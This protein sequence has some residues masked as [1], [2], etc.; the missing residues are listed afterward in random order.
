[1][2]VSRN[3]DHGGQTVHQRCCVPLPLCILFST[4]ALQTKIKNMRVHGISARH[5]RLV[6]MLEL[7]ATHYVRRQVSMYELQS[8]LT[9]ESY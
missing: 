5:R 8:T 4:W 1:M 7:S 9:V 3:L 2:V 6:P